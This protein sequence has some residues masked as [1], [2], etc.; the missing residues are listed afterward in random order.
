MRTQL[1]SLLILSFPAVASAGTWDYEYDAKLNNYYGYTDYAKDYKKLHKQN[2]I[3]S[4]LNLFG[5]ASYEFNEC[6]KTS[7]IGYFI[8]PI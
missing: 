2:N 1:L 7:L 5:R 8:F 3:N 4:S 6:Y